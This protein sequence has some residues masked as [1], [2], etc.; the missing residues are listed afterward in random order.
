[1]VSFTPSHSIR[2]GFPPGSPPMSSIMLPSG[3]TSPIV[4]IG[5]VTVAAA[6]PF[7]VRHQLLAQIL[8]SQHIAVHSKFRFVWRLALQM[9]KKKAA[10]EIRGISSSSKATGYIYA[11]IKLLLQQHNSILG[12]RSLSSCRTSTRLAILGNLLLKVT[13]LKEFERGET[14]ER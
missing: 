13:T 7:V 12:A 8:S 11:P 1:M 5:R 9:A 10:K 14:G 3:K 6:A 4:A 2:Q